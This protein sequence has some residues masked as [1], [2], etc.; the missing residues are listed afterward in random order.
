MCP[1]GGG[2]IDGGPGSPF[3]AAKL[4]C[5]VLLIETDAHG[6]VLV[7]TGLGLGDLA[8]P[9]HRLGGLFTSVA[10]PVLDE[11]ET[12]VRRLEALGFS[13][14][15]VRH[16]VLTHMDLDHA[17]GLGDFR[18]ATVHIT[19]AEHHGAVD[20]PTLQ[21]RARYRSVQWAHRPTFETY[22][23]AGE[24]WFGFAAVRQ[25]TGLPPEILLIPLTGHSRGHAAVAVKHGNGWLLHCG[26]GYF[27]E[28][29]VDPENPRCPPGL[30]LFQNLVAHDRSRM[31]HNKRRLRDLIRCHADEVDVFCAHDETELLR[32]QS[33]RHARP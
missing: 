17:G 5:H 33:Q 27:H 6:L 24:P 20:R 10:R 16:V 2:F 23:P 19:R 26:D 30:Q 22:E 21:E 3:G 15:D 28:D 31:R 4:I 12:A 14:A 25:L 9:K 32:L 8:D 11:S 29:E 7:D 1:L 18:E 13:P